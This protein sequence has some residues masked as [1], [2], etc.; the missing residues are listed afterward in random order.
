MNGSL[1][2]NGSGHVSRVVASLKDRSPEN[3]YAA[4]DGNHLAMGP[5]PALEAEW[6]A[7]GIRLPDLPAMR[8][9][10]LDRTVAQL[11]ADGYDGIIVLDPMNIRYVSDTTNMQLWI[12][13]NA[14][15]YAWVGTDGHVVVWDYT[16]CEFFSGHSH[17]IAEV[18]PS[19][20]LNYFTGGQRRA[21]RCALWVQEFAELIT[22]RHGAGARIAID[23]APYDCHQGLLDAGFSVGDGQAV[24]EQ[25]RRIKG[26]DEIRAMQCSVAACEA[27]MNDMLVGFKP[28]MTEREVWAILHAGNIARAGEWIETQIL[29]SGPRTNPW[30]QEASSRVIQEGELLGYDTDLVGPY[31][32]MTDISRT[33]VVGDAKPNNHQQQLWEM[34]VEQLDRNKDLLTP[35]RTFHELTHEAWFP[36]VEDYRYYS[37]L[38]HGVGQ[39]DEYPMIQFPHGWDAAGYDGVVEPGM[40]FTVESF[41]GARAGG[42]GMKLENQYVV[43]ETGPELLSHF[44]LELT[45]PV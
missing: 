26:P 5:G 18:R 6:T 27:A 40:C 31:G 7:A 43:T 24:M 36:P 30:M 35:G 25:A 42:E 38:F 16:N 8:Q 4:T 37:C 41:I 17:V 22:D 15:R 11:E 3:L 28:G 2:P 44:P 21:E 23:G 1:S 19:I 9:Y 10:R 14:T 39:C 34:A 32:M 45:P 12:M 29:S 20:G 33:W 13:H